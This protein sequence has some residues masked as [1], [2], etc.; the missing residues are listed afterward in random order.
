M[1]KTLLFLAPALLALGWQIQDQAAS[2]SDERAAVERAMLDYCEAFYE[3][4]PEYIERS[5]SK[6]L[7]KFG[8]WR[9]AADQEY[10]GASMNFE[11][12][13]ALAKRWNTDGSRTTDASPKKVEVFDVLDQTASG[14]LTAEWGIDYFHL[15]KEDGRWKIRNV[16]WQ[17]HPVE[18]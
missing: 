14:K 7:T 6:D 1:T 3:C 8:Y 15:A 10:R 2:P 18:Q 9:Q 16:I 5:V 17:S 4:K 11:Q 12:A 13:V